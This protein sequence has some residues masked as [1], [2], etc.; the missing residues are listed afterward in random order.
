MIGGTFRRWHTTARAAAELVGVNRNTAVS[1]YSRLRMIIARELTKASPISGEIVW[2]SSGEGT[3]AG[4]DVR[5]VL[6]PFGVITQRLWSN[7]LTD[8]W[9]RESRNEDDTDLEEAF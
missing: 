4:E 9:P 8:F 5:D 3:M 2:E 6:I 7:I 1:F